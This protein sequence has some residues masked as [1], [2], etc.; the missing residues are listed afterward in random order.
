M[1]E[2]GRHRCEELSRRRLSNKELRDELIR[3]QNM[4]TLCHC[5]AEI[6]RGTYLFFSV[7]DMFLGEGDYL[8]LLFSE[9][10]E[11]S[12]TQESGLD[13]YGRIYKYALI[14]DIAEAKL[15]GHFTYYSS[16]LDG[17]LVFLIVFHYGLLPALR[18]GLI[19][20][21]TRLCEETSADCRN[22][23]DMDVKVYMSAVIDK[24]EDIASRYHRLLAAATLHRYIGKT[25]SVSVYPQNIPAPGSPSPNQLVAKDYAKRIANALIENGDYRTPLQEAISELEAAPHQSV[26]ALKTH[27][28]EF[29]ESICADLKTR[30]LPLEIEQLRFELQSLLDSNNW[31][32]PVRWLSALLDRA[33]E[34]RVFKEQAHM[35]RYLTLAETYIKAQLQNPLLSEKEIAE[36]IGISASYLSTLFRRQRQTTPTKYIRDLRLQQAVELLRTTNFTVLEVCSACGFGSPETFHRVFKAEFAISPGKLKKMNA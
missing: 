10:G 35:E 16:E 4:S 5:S 33:A 34:R 28:G 1:N 13:V 11:P 9:N 6:D 15:Q 3:R 17:R 21:L 30:G 18:D 27:F 25:T 12:D 32:D 24:P 23:Y 26:D 7:N 29:F 8:L 14:R 19:S 36:H 22:K 31:I 2:Y 20:H